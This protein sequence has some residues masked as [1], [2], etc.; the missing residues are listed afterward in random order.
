[1]KANNFNDG[2]L[3]YALAGTYSY[4]DALRVNSDPAR[5]AHSSMLG[6]ALKLV[7]HAQQQ[8]F[9]QALNGRLSNKQQ[10]A[11]LCRQVQEIGKPVYAPG[12]LLSQTGG[13]ATGMPSAA[14]DSLLW[15]QALNGYLHCATDIVSIR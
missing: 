15:K 9:W 14:G 11:A 7:S 8:A 13:S 10:L 5:Q 12:Y 3:L 1:M 4:F 2:I 6:E